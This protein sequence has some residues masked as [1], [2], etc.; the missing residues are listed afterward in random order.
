MDIHFA[1]M[2]SEPVCLHL[3]ILLHLLTDTALLYCLTEK[4]VRSC[5]EKVVE[6]VG[7]ENWKASPTGRVCY[8]IS[9]SFLH[10]RENA[11]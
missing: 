3:C 10:L 5:K 1:L 4:S 11:E 6:V 2:L 9:S 8:Y 7:E